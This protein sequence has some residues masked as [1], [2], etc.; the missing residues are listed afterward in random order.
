MTDGEFGGGL[1]G[2]MQHNRKVLGPGVP[3]PGCKGRPGVPC[4]VCNRGLKH[5][6][7]CM[8]NGAPI[9]VGRVEDIVFCATC[10]CLHAGEW[11]PAVHTGAAAPNGG[12]KSADCKCRDGQRVVL[13]WNRDCGAY[14]GVCSNCQ[15]EWELLPSNKVGASG[16]Y[17][18]PRLGGP[19]TEGSHA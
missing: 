6:V 11:S 18:R 15:D 2:I 10:R 17:Q 12:P 14:E 3:C 9:D 13:A 7:W 5:C 19:S 8:G 4:R 1:L 16:W